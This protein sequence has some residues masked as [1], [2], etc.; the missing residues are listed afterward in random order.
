MIEIEKT[1]R[2]DEWLA[3]LRDR[4]AAAI[5]NGRLARLQMGLF[6]DVKYIGS[7]VS[8]LRIHHGPGYRIYFTFRATALVL[9]ICGGEKGTQASDIKVAIGLAA[10]LRQPR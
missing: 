1:D 7:G 10:S 2:F 8:E 9:L 3:R 4:D 5:V 6:G